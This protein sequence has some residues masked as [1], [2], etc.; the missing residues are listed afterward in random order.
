M[1]VP[2]RAKTSARGEWLPMISDQNWNQEAGEILHLLSEQV[3]Q[4]Q[5]AVL[6]RD[7][8]MLHRAGCRQTELL[9]E[10]LDCM[11]QGRE[12]GEQ[13]IGAAVMSRALALRAQLKLLRAILRRSA[14]TTAVLRQAFLGITSGYAPTRAGYGRGD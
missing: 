1:S 10:L 8:P 9:R 11:N 13:R 12:D 2:R 4:S 5:Q 3:A 14:A 7:L 6:A